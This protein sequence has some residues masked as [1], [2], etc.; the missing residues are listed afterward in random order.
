MEQHFVDRNALQEEQGNLQEE[1][2]KKNRA[3]RTTGQEEQ[4]KKGL[5]E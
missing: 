4:G 5:A 2:G 3:R 1:Q